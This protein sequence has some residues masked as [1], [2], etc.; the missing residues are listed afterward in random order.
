LILSGYFA[1]SQIE[2]VRF[3]DSTEFA[4]KLD[5]L[6]EK[7]SYQKTLV[8]RFETEILSVLSYYPE[9]DS[10]KI[11]FKEATIKASLNARPTIG[12]LLFRRR[13]KRTYVIRIK[14]N[15]GDSVAT[16][17]Q[18]GFNGA[19]GVLGHELNHIVDYSNRSFFGIIGRLFNYTNKKGKRSY[20]G[21]IDRMTVVKGLGWQLYD[22]EDYVFNKSNAKAK[23]KAYKKAVYYSPEEIITI[24]KELEEHN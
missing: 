3:L 12:S 11:I 2:Q 21:E 20:E 9:L 17:D 14:P 22:W 18:V 10:T 19:V 8:P 24:I 16:L 4:S 1:H 5:S 23:Y 13:S 6:R 15:T 7:C